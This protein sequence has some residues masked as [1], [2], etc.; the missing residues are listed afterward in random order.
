MIH[1]NSSIMESNTFNAHK[2]WTMP[3]LSTLSEINS[4]EFE[5]H[6]E[7]SKFKLMCSEKSSTNS[8]VLATGTSLSNSE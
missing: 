7:V 4:K 3:A 6:C 5:L 8:C 1:L 2:V